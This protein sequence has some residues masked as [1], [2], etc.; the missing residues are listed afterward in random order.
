VGGFGGFQ[1]TGGSAGDIGAGGQAVGGQGGFGVDGGS[2]GSAVD[3]CPFVTNCYARIDACRNSGAGDCD[4]M[5]PACGKLAQQ[6]GVPQDPGACRHNVDVC[7]AQYD[8]CVSLGA[9]GCLHIIDV[10]AA[11]AH[12]CD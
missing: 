12:D 1:E 2:G 4:A 5:I 3:P 11:L 10:C 8:D 9:S 7:L 6:C